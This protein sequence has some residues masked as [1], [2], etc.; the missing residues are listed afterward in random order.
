M[1]PFSIADFCTCMSRKM[2]KVNNKL[3]F[4]YVVHINVY[5]NKCRVNKN[6]KKIPFICKGFAKA[7]HLTL[8]G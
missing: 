2:F 1:F 8:S 5:I 6:C 7:T 4:E 3:E